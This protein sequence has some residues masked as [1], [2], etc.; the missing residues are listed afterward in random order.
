WRRGSS[1][2]PVSKSFDTRGLQL[3]NR[4]R[5]NGAQV[6]TMAHLATDSWVERSV[7]TEGSSRLL[8]LADL[9]QELGAEPVAEEARE[10][11][12]RVAEGRFYVAC[13]GQFKRGKSTLL[14]ALVG[15][16][17]HRLRFIPLKRLRP[18]Q[19]AFNTHNP[20]ITHRVP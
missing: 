17:H 19:T 13:L 20:C 11:A 8:R 5:S 4:R 12:A 15:Y 14:N 10:L 6:E 2:C 16:H 18:H 7:S 3:T 1:R 9:A